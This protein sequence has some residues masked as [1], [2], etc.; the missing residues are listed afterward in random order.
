[1]NIKTQSRIFNP[2]FTTKFTGHGLAVVLGIVRG[3]EG[4]LKL[5]SE[6]G[7][8]INF[9]IMLPAVE[10][11][12]E[13]RDKETTVAMSWKSSGTILL[14]DDEETVRTV[15]KTMLKRLGFTVLTADNGRD[16]VTLYRNNPD[17]IRCVILDLTMPHMGGEETF[18]ELKRIRSDV[19]ILISSGYN[20]RG[21]LKRFTGKGIARFIQKPYRFAS[22]V[23]KLRTIL[24]N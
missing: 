13:H 1:M 20:E 6:E 5:Y 2:F 22:L 16:A 3:H 7:H 23:S 19:K 21:V 9:K 10:R 12:I 15:G 18:T 11:R 14:V 24:E 17:E 4:S 8:G